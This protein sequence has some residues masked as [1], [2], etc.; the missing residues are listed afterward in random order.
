M[1]SFRL[2]APLCALAG[3]AGAAA[4][5]EPVPA[6]EIAAAQ[7]IEINQRFVDAFVADDADFM[8]ELLD[9]RFVYTG[10]DGTW[11]ARADFLARMRAPQPLSGASTEDVRVRLFGPVALV[12]AAFKVDIEDGTTVQIRYTDVY[13]WD[14][15]RWRL[16]SA[17]HTSLKPGVSI[18][19]H[20]GVVPAHAAWSGQDPTGDDLEVLRTLNE[21]Y[22]EAFRAADV[23]WYDAHLA[24]DYVVTYGDGSFHD[25]AAA[26]ADFAQPHYATHMKSFPVGNVRIDRHGDLAVIRAENAYQLKDGRKGVNRYTDVWLKHDGQWRCLAAHITVHKAAV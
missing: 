7:L 16:A 12:H 5:A 20:T 18:E 24:P 8:T 1:T 23:A 21:N 9:E 26:L 17:Q 3:L 15:A 14:G 19:Q 22:V 4:T 11:L 2:A 13:S 25:R 10:R 6:P